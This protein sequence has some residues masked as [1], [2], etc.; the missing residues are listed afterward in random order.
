MQ[1][2]KYCHINGSFVSLTFLI[3]CVGRDIIA[4]EEE[5]HFTGGNLLYRGVVGGCTTI[6][7]HYGKPA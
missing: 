2:R 7:C 6:T 4:G 1:R 3:F 5:C